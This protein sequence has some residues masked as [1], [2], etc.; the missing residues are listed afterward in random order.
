MGGGWE[1]ATLISC[2]NC[3]GA[4]GHFHGRFLVYFGHNH[5]GLVRR[6]DGASLKPAMGTFAKV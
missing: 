2:T 6:L 3:G 1:T 5:S 4:F